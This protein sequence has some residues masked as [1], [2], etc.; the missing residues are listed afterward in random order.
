MSNLSDMKYKDFGKLRFLDFFPKTQEY[1]EDHEGGLESG[2]GL[3]CFE[4]YRIFT[5]FTSPAD[6]PWRTSEIMLDFENGCPEPHA[7]A[8]L[9]SLGLPVRRGWS[10]DQIKQVLGPAVED[11]PTYLRYIIG[12][13]WPYCLDLFIKPQEGMF[14]AWICRKDLADLQIENES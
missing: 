1:D 4:G 6:E 11:D 5:C 12:T 8:L 14:K 3:A 2:I 9:D 13:K 10:S 7:H